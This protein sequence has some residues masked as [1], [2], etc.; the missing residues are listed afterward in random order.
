MEEKVKIVSSSARR[1]AAFAARRKENGLK[2]V[3]LWVNDTQNRYINA[4]LKPRPITLPDLTGTEAQIKW[5]QEIR[6]TCLNSLMAYE[7]DLL[8][9]EAKGDIHLHAQA[10]N[11]VQAKNHAKYWIENRRN[12]ARGH[13]QAAIKSM[14]DA[15]LDL[16]TC[17]RLQAHLERDAYINQITLISEAPEKPGKLQQQIEVKV[18]PQCVRLLPSEYDERFNEIVKGYGFFW[19]QPYWSK[20]VLTELSTESVAATIVYR[21]INSKYSCV[22]ADDAVRKSVSANTYVPEPGRILTAALNKKEKPEFKL[23]WIPEFRLGGGDLSFLG[24]LSGG[25]IIE[26]RVAFIPARHHAEILELC[27]RNEFFIT[28]SA[29]DL[30]QAMQNKCLSGIVVKRTK[31]RV[32]KPSIDLD[33]DTHKK[34][35]HDIATQFLDNE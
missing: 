29:K 32:F 12:S 28:Q 16:L 7:A 18:E 8:Q 23:S 14:L 1:Q 20:E 22:V 19:D 27:E 11:V 9:S 30:S 6:A 17:A 33:A 26:S 35:T 3:T 21:L 5:A 34:D 13:Y 24:K 2:K 31:L 15:P 4:Y 25:H 10:M